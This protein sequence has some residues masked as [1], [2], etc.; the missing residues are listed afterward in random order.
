[1]MSEPTFDHERLDVYR[2]STDDVAFS[3]Q[4]ARSLGA[5]L[6]A[7]GLLLTGGLPGAAG[8]LNE[9]ARDIPVAFEADV[10]VVGGNTWSVTAAVAAA[11]AG[12]SVFLAAP[13]P[14]LGDDLAGTLRLRLEAG[15]ELDDPLAARFFGD[16]RSTTPLAV[17]RVLDEALV[18]AGV[19]FLFGCFATDVL[20][21][22]QGQPAGIVMAN[23]VGRQAIV[24]RVIVDATERG[25]VARLAGARATA[26][27]A[28]DVKFTR[29]VVGPR[30]EPD[31][32]QAGGWQ[33]DRHR[34]PEGEQGLVEHLQLPMPDSSFR[35]FAPPEQAAR[36][37]PIATAS[38]AR[39][40]PCLSHHRACALAL[41][42]IADPAAAEPLARLL[43]KP[44]MRGHAMTSLE[45]LHQ[46][47]DQ[48]RREGALREIVL[49]RALYH[50]G[51]WEGL[52]KTI[53][54]EYAADVRGLFARHARLVLE[55]AEHVPL[56]AK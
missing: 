39:R 13:R 9:S 10:V 50:C 42:Q 25:T 49:A 36:R 20:R 16:D 48:R 54:A 21:D 40:N 11:Q 6:A 51:D 26:W 15:Q 4:L 18:Q 52:G 12:A 37:D 32:D 27:Q 28:G 24:A 19:E 5:I 7:W 2:L 46:S 31:A 17:K 33:V 22:A 23:R 35:S 14:Y 8:T 47:P 1:M 38:S 53:L 30:E 3:C 43:H 34:F 55:A 56:P 41:E 29:V 45:P 44:A